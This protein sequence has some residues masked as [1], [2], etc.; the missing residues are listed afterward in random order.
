MR[1]ESNINRNPRNRKVGRP[2]HGDESTVAR[3]EAV[4]LW[5][6]RP[7]LIFGTW[8]A[9]RPTSA[10]ALLVW[11]KVGAGGMGDLAIPWL[12]THEE[13]YVL[14]SG[15]VGRRSDGVLSVPPLNSGS[16]SRP[17]HPT[18]KPVGLIE[19]LIDKCPP[20]V[21]ADPFAGSGSTLIAA[22][23][24]GRRAVG[25]EIDEQYCEVIAKRLAQDALDFGAAL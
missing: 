19:R 21:I 16:R 8:R 23:N 12:P 9:A 4:Q 20:G 24:L 7:A 22:R 25:V 3:D 13:I 17:D 10:R 15:F 14:G 5:G 1:Y 11:H 2:V 18:P 6:D